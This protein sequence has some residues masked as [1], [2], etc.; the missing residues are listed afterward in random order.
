[1][2]SRRPSDPGADPTQSGD[3]GTTEKPEAPGTTL[4]RG[5]SLKKPSA[6]K[7][8]PSLSR[9]GAPK[10]APSLS[11]PGTQA[12]AREVKRPNAG[13]RSSS[14]S[15]PG[16]GA[17]LPSIS[18]PGA[19][20]QAAPPNPKS[21]PAE[22]P[23]PLAPHTPPQAPS[24]TGRST[25]RRS[26]GISIIVNV[27]VVL[28]LA[29]GYYFYQ[30]RGVSDL[31]PEGTPA[32]PFS[33][34]TLSGESVSLADYEGKLLVLHFWATYCGPCQREIPALN[35]IYEELGPN[36]AFLAVESGSTVRDTAHFVE[37]KDVKY[38]VAIGTPAMLADYQVTALPTTYI[39]GPDGVIRSR[40]LGSAS[41]FGTRTRMNCA[42]E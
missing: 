21:P 35:E 31:L 36:E 6:A 10:R 41:R 13:E 12:K 32:P 15:H 7:R 14:P 39:V 33:L 26:R 24:R 19:E 37:E 34:Q 28:A 3:Q 17:R 5:P 23:A 25:G 42:K 9:D 38:P 30:Y 2:T 4:P 27:A 22:P 1:M 20:K 11:R 29:A 16:A 18:R 40:D 8:V